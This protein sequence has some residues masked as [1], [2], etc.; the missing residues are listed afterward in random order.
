MQIHYPG[1]LNSVTYTAATEPDFQQKVRN[2]AK[3]EK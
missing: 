1:N 2:I 3:S